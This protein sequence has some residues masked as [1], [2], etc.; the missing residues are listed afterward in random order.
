MDF[1]KEL[2]P[3][4]LVII[5]VVLSLLSFIFRKKLVASEDKMNAIAQIDNSHSIVDKNLMVRSTIIWL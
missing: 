5:V 2:T 4:V 1:L 3:V